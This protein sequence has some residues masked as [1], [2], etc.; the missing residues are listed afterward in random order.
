MQWCIVVGLV[1]PVLHQIMR[2]VDG[3][4]A[5]QG[6]LERKPKHGGNY[7]EQHLVFFPKSAYL[8]PIRWKIP[9]LFI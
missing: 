5:T 8:S 2:A 3:R 9:D 1:L 4:G 7:L 6:E